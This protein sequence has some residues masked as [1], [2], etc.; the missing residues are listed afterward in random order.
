L[1]FGNGI[2]RAGDH[3]LAADSAL[4]HVVSI[5]PRQG[6]S[7]VWL[8]HELLAGFTLTNPMPGANGITVHNGWVYVYNTGQAVLVPCRYDVAEPAS[9]LET[10]A[11]QLV[12]DD[13]DVRSDGHI[14]LATHF[15]N[16]VMQLDP[17][18]MRTQSPATRKALLAVRPWRLVQATPLSC[19]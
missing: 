1:A 4:S 9:Q 8:Q 10:V 3:L 13:F 5:D 2:A 19:W 11:D 14:Y 12:A 18:G 6:T 17:D 7:S 16:R 15:L